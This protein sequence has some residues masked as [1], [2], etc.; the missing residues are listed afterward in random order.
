MFAFFESLLRPTD[1]PPDRAPPVLAGRR[2]LL[3]FYL[4]FIGQVRGL[5]VLLFFAGMLVALLD[6]TIPTMIGRVVTL[7]STA[8][9]A[10]I[11]ESHWHELLIMAGVMLVL[12][13]ASLLLRVLTL[14]PIV[15]SRMPG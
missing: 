14:R 13:P 3:R 9:P 15:N 2:G 4:H 5:L 1:I 8:T 11:F 10:T 7:V 6:V 12:R